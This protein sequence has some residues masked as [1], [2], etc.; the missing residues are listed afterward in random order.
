MKKNTTI[1]I[2]LGVLQAAFILLTAFQPKSEDDKGVHPSTL[3]WDAKLQK[4]AFDILEEKYNVCHRKQNP[5]MRFNV[6]NMEK[7]A[8]KIYKTVFIDRRM[9]KGDKF[10]LSIEE[11][12][13]LQKWLHTQNIY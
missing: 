5:F 2:T 4:E 9:P 6:K 3:K 13:K 1:I 8:P 12:N 7:R 11:Y 10:P